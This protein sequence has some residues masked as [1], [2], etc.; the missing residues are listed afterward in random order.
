MRIKVSKGNF[1]IVQKRGI[2]LYTDPLGAGIAIAFINKP[3][4]TFGLL[5]YLFPTREYDLNFNEITV[6]S[7][8]SLLAR[9]FDEIDKLGLLYEECQWIV[10]GAGRFKNNPEFFDL[11]ERNFRIAEAWLRKLN[12]WNRAIKK[13]GLSAPIS[14]AVLGSE[15]IFE[16]KYQNRVEKYE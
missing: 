11:C 8:E 15:G 14:L 16:V 12:L 2:I 13:T 3:K 7:G 9:F 6:Y 1:E 4:S 10:A 5:A